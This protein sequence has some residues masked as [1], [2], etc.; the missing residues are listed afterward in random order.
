MKKDT[1]VLIGKDKR[2]LSVIKEVQNELLK[3]GTLEVVSLE[4]SAVESKKQKF[5]KRFTA[6]VFRCKDTLSSVLGK[7][8]KKNKGTTVCSKRIVNLF[9]RYMPI[10][11]FTD[12]PDVLVAIEKNIGKLG[13]KTHVAA[14]CS[15]IT[16][17]KKLISSITEYYF[18]D[19]IEAR[20]KLLPNGIYSDKIFVDPVPCE[21][22]YFESF[23]KT[24]ASNRYFRNNGNK[25]VVIVAE[26][27][28]KKCRE[29]ISIVDENYRGTDFV[30]YAGS[31]TK[32][33]KTASEKG[34]AV[35]D[36]NTDKFDVFASADIIVTQ[37]DTLTVKSVAAMGIPLVIY[38]PMDKIKMSN[39]EY[40]IADNSAVLAYNTDEF[41]AILD[42]FDNGTLKLKN[43]FTDVNSAKNIAEEIMNIVQLST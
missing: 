32:A 41:K 30:I 24:E 17:N 19:N 33:Y 29:I 34:A 1:V 9:Y 20:S 4:K 5:I 3:K 15:E 16:F 42:S 40:L 28:D 39:A 37:G 25:K 18:V 14:F 36:K 23:D 22:K 6:P 8:N 11:V 7:E 31:N 26:S 13:T 10:L 21:K 38:K 35:F 27:S 2:S 12:S 43:D